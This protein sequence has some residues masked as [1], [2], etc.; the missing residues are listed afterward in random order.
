MIT[1]LYC[2]IV[3]AWFQKN[4]S[5]SKYLVR[6]VLEEMLFESLNVIIVIACEANIIYIDHQID[7]V[8]RRLEVWWLANQSAVDGV[9]AYVVGYEAIALKIRGGSESE[10]ELKEEK[11]KK[12]NREQGSFP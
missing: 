5:F 2:I 4:L 6:K 8:R 3:V 11:R 1:I 9:T 10:T 7:L 12:K